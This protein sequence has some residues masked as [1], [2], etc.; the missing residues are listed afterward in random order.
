MR[1]IKKEL[2]YESR[3][4]STWYLVPLGDIHLGHRNF[5]E[6][7]FYKTLEWVKNEP[8]AVVLG[9]GD[10]ADCINAKDKRHDYNSIDMRYISPDKQYEQIT[11]DFMEIKPKIVGLLDGNHDYSFW[12][13]HNHNYVDAMAKALDTE[14]A[15]I[16][17]YVRLN[18]R[19]I[20]SNEKSPVQALN[21]YAHHGW[22]GARTDGYKVKTIQDLASIFPGLHCY[23]MG[24]VHQIGEAP[25]VVSLY[26]DQNSNIREWT[27]RYVF[28]GSYIKGYEEGVGS[29]VEARGYRPTSLGSPIIEIKPN[30]IDGGTADKM[31]PPF[32]IRVSTLDN[33]I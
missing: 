10:Y 1:V 9:M 32:N 3:S 29:Y 21:I 12:Q 25:P 8:H 5:D 20:T 16:S 13:R 31:Q 26:V 27:Q 7:R 2:P 23:L 19:R 22:T 4:D 6:D 18:L 30:R 11:R 14:Y 15:G 17:A 28:T 33:I 24:H